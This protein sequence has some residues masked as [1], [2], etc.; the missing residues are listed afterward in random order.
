[1][2]IPSNTGTTIIGIAALATACVAVL[3]HLITPAIA[4]SIAGVACPVIV[5]GLTMIVLPQHV[6]P[7]PNH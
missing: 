3:M 2:K 5:G 4:S 7:P 1:M 6:A